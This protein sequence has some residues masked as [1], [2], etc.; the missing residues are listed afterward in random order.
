MAL[1]RAEQILA[2]VLT[3]VTG[4]TSTGTRVARDRIDE[5]NCDS[6]AVL[7]VE[8]GADNV[9]EGS[10]KNMAFIDS[11]LDVE[12]DVY[13]KTNSGLTT[14][15]N[16]SRK[17]VHIALYTDYTQGLSFV[18]DTRYTGASA[19]ESSGDAEKPVTKQR[20]TYEI[21]YRHSIADP[22]A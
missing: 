22:S 1:H 12:I 2:A 19:P 18:V 13:V 8:M 11:S 21:H 15:L 6:G 4:L 20:L 7:G 3:N 5:V 14:A 16:L 9:L 17:E 10:D